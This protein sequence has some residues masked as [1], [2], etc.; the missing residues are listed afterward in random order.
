M[1][2]ATAVPSAPVSRLTQFRWVICG[3]LFAATT[4]NYVDRAAFG[5]L[6]PKLK[7]IFGWS[8][9]DVAAISLWFEVAYAIGLAFAG[10][11]LDRVGTRLALGVSF[12]AWCAASMMH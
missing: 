12:A 3:L 2:A 1:P 6:A 7:E 9:G 4:I 10:R 11:I 8:S 5:V